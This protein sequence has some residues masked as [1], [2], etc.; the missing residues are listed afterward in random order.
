MSRLLF[1]DVGDVGITLFVILLDGGQALA[2]L[3]QLS[4]FRIAC[5]FLCVVQSCALSGFAARLV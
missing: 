4:L 3:G 5:A 2:G 1:L